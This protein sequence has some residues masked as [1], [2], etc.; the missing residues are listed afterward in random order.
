MG[1]SLSTV[2]D[3][4]QTSW[5]IPHKLNC[6]QELQNTQIR[7][8][9]NFKTK[10][11]LCFNNESKHGLKYEHWWVSDGKWI[12]EFGGGNI[13]DNKVLVHCNPRENFIIDCEFDMTQEVKE[14]M[15]KVCGASN[16]SL[17]LRNCEHV[18]RYIRYGSWLCFQMVGDGLLKGLFFDHMGMHTKVINTFP[19]E[20]KPPTDQKKLTLYDP[21]SVNARVNWEIYKEAL[22]EADNAAYNIVILGPTGSGKSTLINNFFNLTVCKTGGSAESVTRQVMFHE[23]SYR[24]FRK[25]NDTGEHYEQSQVNV[26]DTIGFCDSLLSASDVLEAIKSS[27]KINLAKIDK[28]VIVCAGRIEGP[29]VQAIRQ[30][31]TWLQF[32]KYKENFVLVY[33]KSD[34][35]SEQ[36]KME[37]LLT[38]C[39]KFG[40]PM[41]NTYHSVENGRNLAIHMNLALGFPS[42]APYEE[43]KK[44]HVSLVD[45]MT[46]PVMKRIPVDKTRCIIL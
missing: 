16:Y 40:V 25:N 4:E 17:A 12:L 10:L 37:N 28:V 32:S 30:F 11:M 23:G 33:N 38:M 6:I 15:K 19:A 45:A 26:I 27:V 9:D 39:S 35:L 13:L 24:T 29:H 34:L 43:V 3:G 8:L 46:V 21:K 44:D 41:M 20:L 42:N 18:A 22:Q 36:Q 14:R 5:A 7:L 31:M 2:W 1:T